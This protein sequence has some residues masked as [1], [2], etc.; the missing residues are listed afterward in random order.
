M[1][2]NVEVGL[3]VK[4]QGVEAVPALARDLET[5]SRSAAISSGVLSG[6]GGILSVGLTAPL[7]A[8]A[9]GAAALAIDYES[10]FAGVVKTVDASKEQLDG[11]SAAFRKMS[12]EIPVSAAALAGVGEAAGQLG[13]K[14]KN[15]EGFTRVM[16]DLG[17]TTNLTSDEAATAL[18][19]LANVTQMPQ[20]EFDRL[21]A[22]IVALGNTSATTERDIV[23][24]TTR[25]AGAGATVG[26]T[27][28]QMLGIA[29]ALSS[30]GIEAEAGGSAISRTMV[31]MASAVSSGGLQLERFASVAGMSSA[32]F[33]AAWKQDAGGALTAFVEGLGKIQS[34]G[35][36]TL[37][38]L[39]DLGV[40][41]VRERQ[42]LLG[43]ANA[44]DLFARSL[45]TSAK[46]WRENTA[47][48]KEAQTRYATTASQLKML[49]NAFID[50]GITIGNA[51]LPAI[52][53]G[54]DFARG[55]LPYIGALADAFG[56]LPVAAQMAAL[57][58]AAIAAG[59]G[60]ALVAIGK[61]ITMAAEAKVALAGM[62]AA[63]AAAAGAAAT[64]A[65][66]GAAGS[67]A[68][69]AGAAGGL[70]GVLAGASGAASSI[71]AVVTSTAALTAG[72]AAATAAVS[73]GLTRA[74]VEAGDASRGTA[75][76][77]S[78]G[79][80]QVGLLTGAATLAGDFLGWLGRTAVDVGGAIVSGL[81]TAAQQ[82][83]D[84]F[85]VTGPLADSMRVAWQNLG[86]SASWVSEQFGKLGQVFYGTGISSQQAATDTDI[87][88]RA[89]AI[90]GRDVTDMATALRLV[91]NAHR[92]M[93]PEL[94]KSA[95]ATR[96]WNVGMA[97]SKKLLD[98]L[99][100][101]M[102]K[103]PKAAAPAAGMS[104]ADI[105]RTLEGK[106]AAEDLERAQALVG[107]T[108]LTAA[109]AQRVLAISTSM[110]S[111][112]HKAAESA[113]RAHDQAL[114]ALGI[115]GSKTQG[116]MRAIE[117]AL[118]GMGGAAAL[119]QANVMAAGER[120]LEASNAGAKL[121]KESEAVVARFLDM[122]IAADTARQT[123]EAM[124]AL[125]K[126]A[127]DT[128]GQYQALTVQTLTWGRTG[129]TAGQG[130]A[131]SMQLVTRTLTGAEAVLPRLT[132]I[133][134]GVGA[135]GGFEAMGAEQ[136]GKV[137]EDLRDLAE[138]SRLTGANV[139][140]VGA[141]LDAAT[142]AGQKLAADTAPVIV[143]VETATRDWGAAVEQVAN[144]MQILGVS[145]ESSLGRIV[146]GFT[147]AFAGLDAFKK[148]MA[149]FG[150]KDLWKGGLSGLLSGIGGALT[151]GKAALGVGKAIVGLFRTSPAEKAAKEAG[152]TLGMSVS[153]ELAEQI[154]KTASSLKVDMRTATLLNLDKAI[155]ESGKP[156][157]AFQAQVSS[158]FEM[159]SRGGAVA[160][161]SIKQLSNAFTEAQKAA[162]A[163]DEAARRMMVGMVQ[164]ARATGAKVPEIRD[165][166]AA[167]LDRAFGGLGALIKGVPIMS[168]DD[169]DS[170]AV[171]IASGFFAKVKEEGIVEAGLAFGDI[172]KAWTDKLAEGGAEMTE[173]A[174]AMLAPFT[175]MAGMAAD[176]GMRPLLE[177]IQGGREFLAGMTD[178]GYAT[179]GM[180]DALGQ[181]AKTSYDALVAKGADSQTALTAIAPLLAD[182]KKSADL[183]GVTLDDNTQSLIAQAEAAGVAFPT[184]PLLQVVDLLKV[185]AVAVGGDIPASASAGSAAFAG[186][187]ASGAAAFDK[188][189]ARAS[190]TAAT[191]ASSVTTGT[192]T[193][194]AA[195]VDFATIAA[196][197]YDTL[198]HSI[199]ASAIT[200][201]N[202]WLSTNA[203]ILGGIEALAA[204]RVTI[205]VSYALEGGAPPVP[206]SFSPG[207]PSF[208]QPARA[209]EMAVGTVTRQVGATTY[210]Y[211]ITVNVT[212]RDGSPQALETALLDMLRKDGRLATALRRLSH[213]EA[214]RAPRG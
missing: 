205:P 27:Q 103:A 132:Q 29:A 134:A 151:A 15:I 161:G 197:G 154:A 203:S 195:V 117:A 89:S 26:M 24:M 179:V 213:D 10:A 71:G 76:D 53:A 64:G 63:K 127:A 82:L 93:P 114:S 50:I 9:A 136:L 206:E 135:A 144:L 59:A 66:A 129:A 140:G 112:G 36:D 5:L 41:D 32:Q 43:L 200:A 153:K 100:A 199:E 149:D 102:G 7:V 42:A 49:G 19:R 109:E 84:K 25:I 34:A 160:A 95:E 77:I 83:A 130:M 11:L 191:I 99:A 75:D 123:A 165:A 141:A 54:T 208:A 97:E 1:A 148:G 133:L 181:T 173:A 119:S 4:K 192:A 87:L 202:A 13:I 58:I 106:K 180:F 121:G 184:E 98:V 167:S 212:P 23:N 131:A 65:A 38:V 169:I 214:R 207:E 14:F 198:G 33:A 78:K 193:A 80:A 17:A 178:S 201:S 116:E 48:T 174:A 190:T 52:K 55:L 177:G 31:D 142:A 113:A 155:A 30:V 171:L 185:I 110:S 143:E 126:A 186:M 96:A 188:L 44:G 128:A 162:Q 67:G 85:V 150:T 57:G 74:L 111:T 81:V 138:V 176:E 79:V 60:P 47:L 183:Y 147:G 125:R 72:A 101:A 124:E 115:A 157:T 73:A 46:A 211:H 145:A 18:A 70:G 6:L 189:D 94:A 68:A 56:R 168:P 139:A 152:R 104:D 69:A 35:G 204:K 122:R 163:G 105:R 16:A 90:A 20:D 88:A 62:A 12:T 170:Q 37:K 8:A 187:G 107:K 3:Q 40:A 158:L 159:V 22:S 166:V 164:Q 61:I 2:V 21:G 120:L 28:A 156:I 209:P 92:G 172:F 118:V 51:L 196:A 39:A 194:G 182:L 175:E 86:E 91:A 137:T 210:N 146:G 45:A 108:G